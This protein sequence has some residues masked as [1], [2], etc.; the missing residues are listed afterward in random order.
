MMKY[1]VMTFMYSGWTSGEDG[2]HEELIK[3]IGD[4]GATGIEAFANH[5]FDDDAL[6]KL[7]NREMKNAAVSMPVMDLL[8]N[9]A[10]DDKTERAAE[11]DKMLKGID[12]CDALGTEIVHVAG[13]GLIGDTTPS[14]GRKLI[15]EGLMEFV[16][17]I[18]KRGMTLAIEDFDPSPDL[19][20]SA[21]DCI[22]ILELT[23][24]RCKFVFDTGNFEA[25]GEHAEDNFEKLIDVTCHFHFKDLAPNNSERGYSGTHFGTGM[26]K[27]R[28]IAGKILD[29]G[30]NGW[31]ALESVVQYPNGP[32][33]TIPKDMKALKSMF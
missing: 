28:E 29:C 12:I 18:E 23:G 4:S 14:D 19:I 33:D 31:V 9:L 21:A 2:S 13:C 7:Y 27:N 1:A 10:A 32:V 3:I 26:V 11:Y 17:D 8:A 24:N 15:A 22:E 5:F 6:V 25:S 16:D 20:C 30:Y